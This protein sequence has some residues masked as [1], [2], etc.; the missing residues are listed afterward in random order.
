MASFAASEAATIL[1]SHEDRATVACFLLD[2]VMAAWL[3]KNTWP[4]VECLVAQSESEKPAT[5]C[6][7]AIA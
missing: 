2:Q 1:A 3:Y 4:D 6:G 7:S 5:G